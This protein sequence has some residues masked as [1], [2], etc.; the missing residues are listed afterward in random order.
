MA[1]ARAR[2][3]YAG[4]TNCRDLARFLEWGTARAP[5]GPTSRG[6]PFKRWALEVSRY[7]FETGRRPSAAAGV[8]YSEDVGGALSDV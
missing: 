8:S 5:N 1:R 3:P 4:G 7:S 6:E 2:R